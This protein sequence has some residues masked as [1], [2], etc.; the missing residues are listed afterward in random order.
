MTYQTYL[1]KGIINDLEIGWEAAEILFQSKIYDDPAAAIYELNLHKPIHTNFF[2]TMV[3]YDEKGNVI[4]E[5][6]FD[7]S[8]IDLE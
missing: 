7:S 3:E 6:I 8:V 5:E 2:C 4:E 1:Y